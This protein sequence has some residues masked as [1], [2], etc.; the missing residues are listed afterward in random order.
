MGDAAT[1]RLWAF[2][3]LFLAALLAIVLALLL[4]IRLEAGRLPGPDLVLA[5]TI[6]WAMRQPD[7]VPILLLAGAMLVAD[8]L[9]MRPP[10]LMAALVVAAVEVIR[11]REYQWRDL[12]LP[13]EW[14]V[15]AA[16]IGGVLILNALVLAIF[17]VPQASLGQI[18]IRL[19]L[20]AAVYPVAALG[21]RYVFRVPRRVGE[22]ELGGRT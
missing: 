4:P 3:A 21:V 22:G 6:A 16:L 18:L 17:L 1:F 9:L 10:G 14:L 15:G 7:H 11:A 13:L 19:I 12:P 2:R 20:T 5:L 8:L